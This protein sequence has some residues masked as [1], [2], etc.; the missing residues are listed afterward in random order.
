MMF[1]RI[2]NDGFM[3]V[4]DKLRVLTLVKTINSLIFY[5]QLTRFNY[6]SYKQASLV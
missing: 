5:S 4:L 2:T 6:C 1:Y 3:T